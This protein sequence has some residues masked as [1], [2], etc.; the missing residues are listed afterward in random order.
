[1]IASSVLSAVVSCH[2]LS[3]YSLHID[4]LFGCVRIRLD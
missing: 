4:S 3:V 2:F 1:M